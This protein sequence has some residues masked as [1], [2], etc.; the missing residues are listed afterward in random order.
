MRKKLII[1]NGVMGVGKT[2]VSKALYKQLD[3]SFWLDGDNCWM[4]NPFEVTSENKYMVIDNITYLINNFIKNSKSKYII[5][6][7]VIH[8]DEIMDSILYKINMDKIDLYKITLICD[9]DTLV[10][11]IKKDIK[12]GIRDEDN[13]KR[14]LDKLKLYKNMNTLKIDTVNKSID[15]IVENIKN[16]IKN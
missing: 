10:K 6:N 2:S 16:I 4:M 1:I 9:E 5:L 12:S 14:S 7:W 3:N 11:R 15:E 13:I 8:T